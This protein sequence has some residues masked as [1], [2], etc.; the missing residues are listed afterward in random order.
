MSAIG[1]A[2]IQAAPVIIAGVATN[3]KIVLAGAAI[4][5]L[6]IAGSTGNP[7]Y[8]VM[9]AILIG[10]AYFIGFVMIKDPDKNK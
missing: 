4:V 9:D 3:N 8:F 5:M 1:I 7:S 10:I 2:L 6:L